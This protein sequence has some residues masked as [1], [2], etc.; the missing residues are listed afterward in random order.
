[1]T[2]PQPKI[3]FIAI[4]DNPLDLLFLSEMVKAYP[5]LENCGTFTN[6]LEGYEARQYLKPDLVFL[7]IEMPAFTGIELL[8]K[9]RDE[10]PMAVFITSH[11]DFALEG[12]ELSALDYVLK[13][14]ME[15]RF[16]VTVARIR[17]FWEMRQK[18]QAYEVLFERETMT[19][20][21]GHNVVKLSQRDIVYLEAMQDY[22]KIVTPAKNYLTLSTLSCFMEQLPSD[23]FMRVHRS[24][25]VALGQVRELRP[26]ELV[27]GSAVIPIGKTYRPIVSKLKM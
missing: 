22:T 7:D 19:I 17:E 26:A 21:E 27:C 13:P 10:V 5:F 9:F 14:I 23:R 2:A 16:A 12:F 24:Y 1:M 11:P 18:S 8:R 6:P 20:K 4:D 25:A 15:E 3:R